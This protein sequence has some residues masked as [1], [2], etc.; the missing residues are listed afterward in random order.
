[1]IAIFF[2]RGFRS[3]NRGI[4]SESKDSQALC[5]EPEKVEDLLKKIET[6]QVC[7][8]IRDYVQKMRGYMRK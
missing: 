4:Y 2:F 1:V 7:D 5:A 8:E 3:K 6:E